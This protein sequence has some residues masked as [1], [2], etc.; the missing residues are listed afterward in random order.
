MQGKF[1][2]T[3]ET[4]NR[5][6]W[7]CRILDV[8]VGGP[9]NQL[10][11]TNSTWEQKRALQEKFIRFVNSFIPLHGLSNDSEG[12]RLQQRIQKV[13][14]TRRS[15]KYVIGAGR[16]WITQSSLTTELH[17]PANDCTTYQATP[18]LQQTRSTSRTILPYER[19]FGVQILRTTPLK[20]M[21]PLTSVTI[22][23]LSYFVSTC[24]F[25]IV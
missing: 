14:T 15:R 18:F 6:R 16:I 25:D 9:R 5:G 1:E 19:T 21:P 2:D 11:S 8:F 10:V 12:I 4:Q 3:W 23:V 7:L 17:V 22:A 13:R 20:S 24:N